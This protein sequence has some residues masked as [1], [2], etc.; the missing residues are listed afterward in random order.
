MHRVVKIYRKI[1]HIFEHTGMPW[2]VLGLR[3]WI[4][5]IF[6]YSGLTKISHWPATTYL[7]KYEYKLP[8]LNPEGA[9]YVFTFF[10]L[11]CPILLTVGLATRLATIPI[12]IMIAIIQVTYL[13]I[14]DHG[15]WA[16]MLATILFY[17]P[18]RISMDHYIKNKRLFQ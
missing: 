17:G 6:W 18:G 16:V 1:I 10:E 8:Y 4:A 12:L 14:S 9:A 13:N 2:L 3:L 15:Y 7:F 11:V 5:R